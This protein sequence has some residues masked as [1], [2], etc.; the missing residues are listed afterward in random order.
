M[1]SVASQTVTISTNPVQVGGTTSITCDNGSPF[2]RIS[3]I[4]D[5][6]AVVTVTAPGGTCSLADEG[7]PM[8]SRYTVTCGTDSPPVSSV[9]TISDV[10]EDEHGTK[11]DCAFN[12][13]GVGDVT[14]YVTG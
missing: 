14:L 11:W 13:V 5:G 12:F 4:R 7:H 1:F 6:I 10:M 3:W 2:S 9:L 8:Y